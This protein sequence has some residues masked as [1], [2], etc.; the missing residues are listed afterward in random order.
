MTLADYA[1]AAFVVLNGGQA[2]AHLP[3]MARIYRAPRGAS[4]VSPVPSPIP[5]ALL[6]AAN[7]ATVSYA[8][9]VSGDRVM[10][11]MF[12]L[13]ATT[14]LA[15][16]ALSAL[17]RRDAAPRA[18]GLHHWIAA[19]RH[20][21]RTDATE[22]AAYPPGNLTPSARHRDEMIRQGLLS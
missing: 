13:N 8:L 1:L 20:H 16:V 21:V 7:I 4:A 22:A 6:A 18:P 19:H 9:A 2:A 5:W 12:A 11:A 17:R 14:C 10:A 15:I 3:Q